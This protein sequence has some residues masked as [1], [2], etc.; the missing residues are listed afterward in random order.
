MAIAVPQTPSNPIFTCVFLFSVL[1]NSCSCFNPKLLNVSIKIQSDSGWSPAGA[2]WY[3]SPIGAG[4]DG[5]SYIYK[6]LTKMQ[7]CTSL[8]FSEDKISS[9]TI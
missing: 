8:S 6:N 4:S 7:N 1:I 2:T 5:K 3:G 9:F